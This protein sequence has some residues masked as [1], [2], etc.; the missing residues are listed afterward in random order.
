MR[1]IFIYS[2]FIERVGHIID[3]ILLKTI[4]SRQIFDGIKEDPEINEELILSTTDKFVI[5][6]IN[7]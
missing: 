7:I 1:H 5:I 3:K 6:N 4:N 2:F